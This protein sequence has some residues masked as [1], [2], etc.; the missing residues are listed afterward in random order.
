MFWLALSMFAVFAQQV[1]AGAVLLAAGVFFCVARSN[2]P[3]CL[4]WCCT[5]RAEVAVVLYFLCRIGTH[6]THHSSSMFLLVLIMFA[7]STQP[8]FAGAVF[9]AAG[10]CIVLRHSQ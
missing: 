6:R 1:F 7:D 10:V 8:V 3:V 9:L 4:S 5:L 2:H